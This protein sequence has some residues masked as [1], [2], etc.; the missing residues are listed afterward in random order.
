MSERVQEKCY[1]DQACRR[2]L[3]CCYDYHLTCPDVSC[4]VSEWSAW[5]G[6]SEPC[7]V[8]VRVRQRSVLQKP[9]NG[10]KPCPP[11]QQTAGCAE[12]HHHQHGHCLKSLVPA[13]ITSGGYGS[14]RKKREVTNTSDAT[15][16]CVEFDLISVTVACHHSTGPHTQ[17]MLY[18]REGHR[19]CMECQSPALAAN[20]KHCTGDGENVEQDRSMSLQWQAMGNPQCRGLWRRIRRQ[21]FCSCPTVH[22]FLFI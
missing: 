14:A 18:L 8:S 13:L 15:G 20:Q 5:S 17:W 21:H 10:G 1:C 11:L 19:V 7:K 4:E 16:Y 12:Y 22:S 6:C 9:E 2:T 3:D